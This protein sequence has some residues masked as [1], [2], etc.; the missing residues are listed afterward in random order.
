MLLIKGQLPGVIK[1]IPRARWIFLDGHLEKLEIL[2]SA[3]CLVRKMSDQKHICLSPD[4]FDPLVWGRIF[5]DRM[6]PAIPVTGEDLLVFEFDPMTP[7][8]KIPEPSCLFG[9]DPLDLS[10]PPRHQHLIDVQAYDHIDIFWDQ[11]QSR[12]PCDIESP[13]RD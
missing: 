12:I 10:S 4:L 9:P 6:M 7:V 11:S 8:E 5:V 3:L 1:G 2:S 13:G